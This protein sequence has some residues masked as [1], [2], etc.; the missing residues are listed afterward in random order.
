MK[1]FV[2]EHTT[3]LMP[4][5]PPI[6]PTP[7][8]T[9]IM[10]FCL[11]IQSREGYYPPGALANYPKGTPAWRNKNP[12]NCRWPFG[13][14]YPAGATGVDASDFLIFRT[15]DEGLEYLEAVTR[16]VCNGTAVAGGA[17]QTAAKNKGLHDCSYLTITQYFFVRDPSSDNNDPAS[18]AEEVAK[19]VGLLT[20]AMMRELL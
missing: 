19:K 3:P 18:Y 14:P 17:Y 4:E 5:T 1:Y 20:T 10:Q 13:T 2:G 7:A 9:K 8:P 6:L 16:A 11:A 12:G 15:Y